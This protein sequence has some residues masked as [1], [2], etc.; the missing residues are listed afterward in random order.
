MTPSVV[1]N[2]KNK[3][4]TLPRVPKVAVLGNSAGV[5]IA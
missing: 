2:G 3:T 5:I 4:E 1:K